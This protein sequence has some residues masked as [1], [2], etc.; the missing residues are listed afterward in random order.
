[1]ASLVL[2][3]EQI[4]GILQLTT[5]NILGL[6]SNTQTVILGYG[7]DGQPAWVTPQ[8][9][10]C[11]INAFPDDDAYDKN[12][13]ESYTSNGAY[14]ITDVGY[15]RVFQPLWT[16]YGPSAYDNADTVRS[17]I[18]T[19]NIRYTYLAPNGMY[20]LSEPS[21]P[22]RLPY[23]AN[24]QWWNRCDLR[25][26]FNVLTIR[27]STVPYL[28]GANIQVIDSKGVQRTIH[29]TNPPSMDFSV[30]RNSQYIPFI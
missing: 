25:M 5:V 18:L 26:K 9:N 20:P 14:Q 29:Y 23:E 17:A 12:R 27:E 21:A 16:F 13:Y 19:E 8:V 28:Q 22:V 30:Q 3:Q 24:S 6:P 2:T 1:M 11:V 10:V 7:S 4:E 15:T